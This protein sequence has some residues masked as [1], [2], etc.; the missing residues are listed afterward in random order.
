MACGGF[1]T[2]LVFV[3]PVALVFGIAVRARPG[4]VFDD[5]ADGVVKH[6]DPGRWC[7]T[8]CAA[9]LWR[10]YSMMFMGMAPLGS[11]LSGALA[12]HI[13][14]PWTLALGGAIAICGAI[15]FAHQ[16]AEDSR[17][18]APA[19]HRAG[20]GRRRTRP[21]A[22]RD[23]R[24][25]GA[26]GG[27]QL[28]KCTCSAILRSPHRIRTER[29]LMSTSA[30]IDSKRMP[31]R[32]TAQGTLRYAARFQGRTAAGHFRE[33]PGGLVFS[34]I[35]IGTYLGEPDEADRQGLRRRRRCGG[36]GRHQRG[37]F[38][39]QLSPAAQRALR[40]RGAQGTCRERFCA[41]TKSSCA[42]RPG[43]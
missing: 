5:D 18:G 6:A 27:R 43:F 21:G 2:C 35:G 13:G 40:R 32:A 20:H 22:W 25:S 15:L 19:D 31:G 23:H 24:T 14:A 38:G 33:I 39:D 41:A 3:F 1:G 11:L 4:G 42:R 30:P 26:V 37:G 29:V 9:A 28:G 16:P 34:S 17:R 10:V 36:R 12:E 7:P 8:G